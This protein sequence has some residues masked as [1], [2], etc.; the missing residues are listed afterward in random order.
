MTKELTL[1]E[2]LDIVTPYG[3]DW[4]GYSKEKDFIF[5]ANKRI[6]IKYTTRMCLEEVIYSLADLFTNKSFIEALC[7]AKYN[8][9]YHGEI[10]LIQPELIHSI[11]EKNGNHCKIITEFLGLEK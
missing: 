7:K 2:I 4:F 3:F 11:T 5:S 8:G 9:K 10:I 6:V 1:Q